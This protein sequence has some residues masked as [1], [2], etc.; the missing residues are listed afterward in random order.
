MRQPQVTS[1]TALETVPQKLSPAEPESRS[2]HLRENGRG[3]QLFTLCPKGLTR[4]VRG[5]DVHLGLTVWEVSAVDSEP[6]GLSTWQRKVPGDVA[7]E[8]ERLP[9]PR[10]ES[11]PQG[12]VATDLPPWA[13]PTCQ[14]AQ[15]MPTGTRACLG[16]G[17]L[18]SPSA[19]TLLPLLS[20][21]LV[22]DCW[23]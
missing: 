18:A 17:L 23:V 16:Q 3:H 5:G 9:S 2:P 22:G 20:G 12:Q 6:G 13:C 4:T 7:Q 19:P 21:E 1:L 8:A 10:A 14:S 15:T 11:I